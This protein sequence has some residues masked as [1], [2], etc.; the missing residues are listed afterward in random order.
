M[1]A[2]QSFLKRYHD[3]KVVMIHPKAK[4]EAI[5]ERIVTLHDWMLL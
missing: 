3:S 5:S 4:I 1:M 2:A